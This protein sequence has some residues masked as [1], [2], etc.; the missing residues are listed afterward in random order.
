MRWNGQANSPEQRRTIPS[1]PVAVSSRTTGVFR[2]TGADLREGERLGSLRAK[3]EI[4]VED[5][6]DDIAGA[7]D[8]DGVADPDIDRLAFVVGAQHLPVAAEAADIVL[9]V[10]RRILDHHAADRDRLQPRHRRQR[11]GAPDLNI[12]GEEFGR[13]L[14]GRELVRDRPARRAGAEAQAILQRQVVHLVD[15]TVDIVVEAGALLLD[16][17]IDGERIVHAGAALHQRIDRETPFLE[18]RDHAHLRIGGHR[19]HLAPGVGEE[20]QRARGGDLGIFL[21]ER[22]RGGVARIDVKLL[23]RFRL[24]AVQRREILLAEVDLA[25]HLDHRRRALRQRR[26]DVLHGADVGGDILA[27]LAVAARRAENQLAA[28][29]AERHGEAI[30]LGLR[31]ERDRLFARATEEAEHLLDEIAHVVVGKSVFQ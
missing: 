16:R 26:G 12:D 15:D 2:W 27:G 25:A 4:D 17:A 24:L 3:R 28:L 13:R 19:A 7:L 21:A 29:V 8:R 10:E 14:L 18:G 22:A 23:A 5:L 11:A 20:A 30:D 6:R 9:V 1:P 31:G